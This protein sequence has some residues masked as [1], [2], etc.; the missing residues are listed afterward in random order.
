[1]PLN[2]VFPKAFAEMRQLSRCCGSWPNLSGYANN[3][4]IGSPTLSGSNVTFTISW[5]N[6]WNTS[7]SPNNWDAVWVFVKRQSCA[8]NLWTHALVSTSN[9]HTVGG[10]VLQV[11]PVTDGMGVFVRRAAVGFGNIA[12]A[13][14]TLV[15]QTPIGGDNFQVHG[16]EMVAVPQGDF[17]IGDA[18]TNTFSNVLITSAIQASGL[19]TATFSPSGLASNVTPVPSTFPMGWNNFYAM[20]YEISQEQYAAFVNTLTY[21]QQTFRIVPSPNAAVGTLALST[22]ASV[23]RNGLRIL[24]SGTPIN[25]PAVIG[26]DLSGNGVFNEVADG[27]NIACNYLSWADMIAYLDWAALRPMSEFEYEKLCRGSGQPVVGG[28]E[29]A[30]GTQTILVALSTALTNAGQNSE[31]STVFG[32]GLTA[33]NNTTVS[34]NGPLRCGFAAGATTRQQAGAGFYGSL[35]LSGNVYEQCFGGY[36]WNWSLF[37][38]ANG[39]GTLDSNGNANTT[40]WPPTGGGGV[41][42]GIGGGVIRGGSWNETAARLVISDRLNISSNINQIRNSAVGGRGVRSF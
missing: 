20:K 22:S 14:V 29:Y 1:M 39:D 27:Q 36:Q 23:N 40:G 18:G 5:D 28:G 30:W 33:Y 21:T 19:A 12:T 35:D 10:G 7:V 11:D 13:T 3:L 15:M 34:T 6:S 24:T 26:C 42:A 8:T 31:A 17:R 4:V 38:N 41:T 25:V 32:M 16:I 9:V 37:T 2:P